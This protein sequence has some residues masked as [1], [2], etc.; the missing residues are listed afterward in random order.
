V[1]VALAG[2][3]ERRKEGRISI[4]IQDDLRLSVIGGTLESAERRE[5]E[6]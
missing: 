1:Y 4:R 2:T 6:R 5:E 3:G